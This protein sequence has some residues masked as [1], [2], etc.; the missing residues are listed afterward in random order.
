MFK[1]FYNSTK[2]D[3]KNTNNES[4]SNDNQLQN[5]A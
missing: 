4:S 2:L 1:H 3:N 5:V